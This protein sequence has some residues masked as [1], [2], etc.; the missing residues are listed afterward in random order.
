MNDVVSIELIRIPRTQANRV[1]S[2]N[3]NKRSL[4]YIVIGDTQHQCN[5]F[6]FNKMI[7]SR[8]AVV[9]RPRMKAA[10]AEAAPRRPM[11]RREASLL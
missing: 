1:I 2:L 10:E 4:L 5:G 3:K 8:N 7:N 11:Q 9:Y 6:L